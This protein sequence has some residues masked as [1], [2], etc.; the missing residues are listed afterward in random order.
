MRWQKELAEAETRHRLS[1]E[2]VR[3]HAAIDEE[4]AELDSRVQAL[5]RNIAAKRLAQ[6]SM[7]GLEKQRHRAD[8]LRY[9]EMVGLRKVGELESLEAVE[10]APTEEPPVEESRP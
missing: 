9:S 7:E 3:E 5:Q 4:L 2:F 1:A 10:L 8:A 6:G